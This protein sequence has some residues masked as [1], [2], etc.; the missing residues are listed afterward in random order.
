[1]QRG[2]QRTQVLMVA[3]Q[4][5]LHEMIRNLLWRGRGGGKQRRRIFY[6]RCLKWCVCV[7]GEIY[8]GSGL[9]GC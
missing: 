2:L 7:Q 8:T 1:M 4:K 6:S 5:K 3:Q 9:T